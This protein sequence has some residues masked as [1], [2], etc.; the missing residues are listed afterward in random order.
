MPSRLAEKAAPGGDSGAAANDCVGA[1]VAG[2]GIGDVHR[3]ALALAVS[4]FLAEQFGEH[5]IGRRALGQ[6]VPV[7]AMRAGDVI[8][9]AQRLANTDR[10]GF[11]ADIEM[12][13]T[14]HDGA[15]VKVIDLLFEQANG[16]HL[17]IGVQPLLRRRLTTASIP[18]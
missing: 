13:E 17:A 9:L 4:R 7:A 18:A 11:L 2:G 12:R 1:Q 10:H 5:A 3:A 16:H 6:A 8:V 14:R 15:R